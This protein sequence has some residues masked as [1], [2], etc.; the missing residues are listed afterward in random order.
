MGRA[1]QRP[2]GVLVRVRRGLVVM[3]LCR[4]DGD[5]I[6]EIR[7]TSA[8]RAILEAEKQGLE[9]SDLNQTAPPAWAFKTF[10]LAK[11]WQTSWFVLGWVKL[12]WKS[13]ERVQKDDAA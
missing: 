3:A 6:V 9:I 13:G 5:E 1:G 7:A 2:V 10:T 4:P 11:G 8:E 12:G